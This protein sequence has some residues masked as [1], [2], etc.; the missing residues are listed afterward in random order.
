MKIDTN[1]LRIRIMTPI[2]L[3]STLVFLFVVLVTKNFV[4]NVVKEYRTFFVSK[5]SFEVKKI[6]ERAI[7]ELSTAQLIGHEVVVKAKQ[8][9]VLEEI[10]LYWADKGFEGLIKNDDSLI[11]YNGLK[12]M[13]P[14]Q[15]FSAIQ[16]KESADIEYDNKTLIG[17]VVS[18]PAWDWQIVTLAEP[19][20]SDSEKQI[21]LLIPL[22][23]LGFVT[24]LGIIFYI[25]H[26]KLGGSID[27]VV[28]D[29]RESKEIADTGITEIDTIGSSINKA[30]AGINR[31]TSQYLTLHN[32]AISL[33]EQSSIDSTFEFILEQTT[34]LISSELS[35]IVL[36]D[37]SGSFKK[38]I[39]IG[40]EFDEGNIHPIVKGILQ[41]M[42]SSSVSPMRINNISEHDSFC[43]SLPS[44]HPELKNFLVYPFLS[45]DNKPL[46]ALCFVNKEK[47]FTDEDESLLRAI[48]ADVSIAIIKAEALSQLKR[49]KQIIESSFELVIIADSEGYIRYVN[50]AFEVITG[51][52]KETVLGKK[53]SILSSGANDKDLYKSLWDTIKSGKMW[54][55][56]FINK[57]KDGE[58]F[59]ASA[60]VF[61]IYFEGELNYVSIQR[62]ITN[63]KKLYEQLV[64][65]QKMEALGTL[66]GGIAH[67]FNNILTAITGYSEILLGSIEENHK[68]HK[69]VR[70]INDAA[71][72]AGELTKK[73]LAITRKEKNEIKA[74]NINN[75]V[76]DV[77]DIVS[78]SLPKNIEILTQLD[79]EIPSIS[80]DPSQIHQVILN[81]AV[82]ARDAMPEGGILTIATSICGF[83]NGF[84]SEN[85]AI[86]GKF[87][88]LTVSDTGA[89]I[90]TKL[91]QRVF[92][93]FFT[94]KTSG[95]GTGLGLYIVHSIVTNHNG[96]IN[97]YSEPNKGT[98]F[99]IY[100]P[101]TKAGSSEEHE[102]E[103]VFKGHGTVL[104]IDD[105]EDV[106]AVCADILTNMGFNVIL[107]SDGKEGV[108]KYLDSKET[109]SI[110][111]LD[112]IMP[113]MGG[114]EVFMTLKDINPKV[115]VI[116][117]SGFS[118]EGYAGIDR[119]MKNGAIAF[120]QKPYSQTSLLSALK[121]A[122]SHHP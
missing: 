29:L 38:L 65:A 45:P 28:K 44:E 21:K 31:K 88:K 8:K 66:A 69:P 120:L 37:E 105:E 87:I 71:K 47:G 43:G 98:R 84:S 22:I 73:L 116:I 70:I 76:N 107:A 58:D 100:L 13:S 112:M 32:I 30:L 90:D 91:Q 64:R 56:E 94:T 24:I 18:I 119:L 59:Y 48:S 61:P 2:F 118:H 27:S 12:T 82:N 16:D 20:I 96:Y 114:N 54:Q 36:F 55:G 60:V 115:K 40:T 67:D 10:K 89:G 33:Y 23:L 9:D 3:I 35:A 4:E 50:P 104:V 52:R 110:V 79:R 14:E 5:H 51:Y 26:K 68:F 122:Q 15:L 97:L 49:F 62:D 108:Q 57:K 74:V 93:P 109:I 53:T 1:S 85:Q 83:V 46:G 77:V 72:R 11:L 34:L 106:R 6:F 63:E 7:A 92:D 95:K 103:D 39:S 19:E 101:V 121:K 102:S 17:F 41:L 117:C 42:Q 75:I 99:N 86:E 25:L 113:R 78:H 111:I 81:L 80:A